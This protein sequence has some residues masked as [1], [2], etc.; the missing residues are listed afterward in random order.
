MTQ[1]LSQQIQI[2][3]SQ[4]NDNIEYERKPITIEF[5]KNF[6]EHRNMVPY[7]NADEVDV[8]TDEWYQR[9]DCINNGIVKNITVFTEPRVTIY[10]NVIEVFSDE[11]IVGYRFGKT[12][13]NV[14]YLS[15]SLEKQ[16]RDMYTDY[17]I[18]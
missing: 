11:L 13:F 16:E 6:L 15:K 9:I 3:S 5:M 8:H 12:G 2:R 14:V 18:K 10:E 17:I 4:P 1:Q 7:P